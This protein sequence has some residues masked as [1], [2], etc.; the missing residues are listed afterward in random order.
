MLQGQRISDLN[1]GTLKL[2]FEACAWDE[3]EI[4]IRVSPPHADE[5]IELLKE[6]G[7]KA[8][9]GGEFSAGQ[10]LE[11]V[12]AMVDSEA[13]WTALGATVA[14]F[15]TRRRGKKTQLKAGDLEISVEGHSVRE[16]EKIIEAFRKLHTEVV[17]RELKQKKPPAIEGEADEE[18]PPA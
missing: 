18:N 12:S 9:L 16:E 11:I 8:S 14:T 7:A 13:L 1:D 3:T 17:E 6:N 2:H 10:T 4:K 5:L 15:L